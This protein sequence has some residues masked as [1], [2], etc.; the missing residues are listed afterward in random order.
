MQLLDVIRAAGLDP[1]CISVLFHVS[2]K[3]ALHR[4]LPM[5]VEEAP[6]LFDAFQN[7]HGKRIEATVKSRPLMMGFVAT[8]SRDY[9][10]A[11]LYDVRG[12]RFRTLAEL[13]A[14][15]R[16][17]LLRA[18]YDDISF[19]QHGAENDYT[20]RLEFDLALRD[21]LRDL[22]GRLIVAKPSGRAYA[23][24][25]ENLATPVIEI[26]RNRKL[27]PPL[28]N[29][30]EVVLSATDLRSLPQTWAARLREW[31]GIYHILD[32]QD[33]ARYVGSAYGVTNILGRWQAH[34][35]G[36]QGITAE[37]ANRDPA[38]LRFSIL[39]L[40]SPAA[41]AS[42]VVRI[43][44]FWKERLGTRLWGLNKN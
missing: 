39:E 23:R 24:L 8:Q 6:D 34:V 15:P 37:L 36:V 2:D 10:F 12:H 32:T 38:G 20:G 18:R 22:I 25:A 28:P 9:V 21:D 19:V 3:P 29:W 4:A 41:V 30:D 11:G 27:V 7:Q 43:E 35:A 31:R 44:G 17:A 5:L 13:D 26:A 40:L 16:R 33:G 42:E 1:Q 14:D